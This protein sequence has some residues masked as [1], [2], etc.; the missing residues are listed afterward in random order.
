MAL[1]EILILSD[2]RLRKVAEPVSV[3][4]EALERL[5]EDMFETMYDAPG[6]GLAAPQIGVNQRVIV[7]DV[8]EDKSAPL[9]LI[10]P[11]LT[12]Q[13]GMQSYQEGCLS[14]PGIYDDV[15]RPERVSLTAYN[16]KGERIEMNADGLLAVCIQ[17]EI[18]H[19]D[20]KL[21]VD[22]LSGLKQNR[23]RKK[24]EKL[25]RNSA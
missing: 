11:E 23:I 22:Y 7:V 15:E 4:D 21:F 25:R 9:A 13:E 14:V 10:N 19:L 20:G 12:S 17:H 2:P 3:F 1:R 24:M 6:I 5:V 18:D 8:S 16:P